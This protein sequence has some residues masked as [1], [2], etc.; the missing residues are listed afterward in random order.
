MMEIERPKIDTASLSPDGRYL[1]ERPIAEECIVIRD[2]AADAI[3]FSYPIEDYENYK[4][5]CWDSDSNLWLRTGNETSALRHT[6]DTW[7]YDAALPRP[8]DVV[9]SYKWDGTPN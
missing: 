7:E 3:L 9:L 8:S 4:G 1:A 2:A 5:F 6:G